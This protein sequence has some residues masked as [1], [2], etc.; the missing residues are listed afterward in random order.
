[1]KIGHLF[2]TVLSISLPSFER[3]KDEDFNSGSKS[4]VLRRPHEINQEEEELRSIDRYASCSFG[5]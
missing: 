2:E 3:E 5:L 4:T 1:M